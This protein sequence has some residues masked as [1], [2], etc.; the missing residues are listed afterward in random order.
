MS[1]EVKRVNEFGLPLSSREFLER[2]QSETHATPYANFVE[3]GAD[4]LPAGGSPLKP[5]THGQL[6]FT[7]INIV[8]RFGQV[9]SVLDPSAKLEGPAFKPQIY[10]C[11]SENFACWPVLDD[12]AATKTANAV[13]Q[14]AP[15]KCAFVQIS[16]RLNQDARMNVC[17]MVENRNDML[18]DKER[19]RWQTAGE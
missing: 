14:D 17:F 9:V 8:D 7:K 5:A 13:I 1:E 4:D 2:I 10:P 19:S 18:K 12:E 11:I 15:G 16:P 3:F 6:V